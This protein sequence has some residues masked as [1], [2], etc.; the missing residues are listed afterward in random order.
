[1][2]RTVH[3]LAMTS[4]LH[5][6]LLGP[7]KGL[8]VTPLLT[9][10]RA[11]PYAHVPRR[12]ARSVLADRLPNTSTSASIPFDATREGPSSI[13]PWNSART[14]AT[15]NQLPTSNIPDGCGDDQSE[16]CL[17]L[18]ITVPKDTPPTAKLPVLLF[19][20]GGAFFLGASTRPYY[21][22]LTLLTQAV[23]ASTPLIFVALNYRLGA[24]GFFHSPEAADLMPPNNGL[25]DQLRAFE[26]VRRHIGGFGGD[27]G[28]VTAVGQSAGGESLSLH[29]ISGGEEKLYRRC[30][31]FSGSPV[32]MPCKT[33][34]E[35]Q[36]NFLEQARGMGI[37]TEGRGSEDVAR[38]M[39]AADVDEVRKLAFVGAPCSS[40]EVLPYEK[41]TML[42]TRRTRPGK[43]LD[44]LVV[45]AAEYDGG[46]SYNMLLNDESRKG[47]AASFARIARDVLEEPQALMDLYEIKEEEDDEMA[48]RKICQF[49]SDIGFL[50][51][52]LSEAMGTSEAD[53]L[54]Q[55][56]ESSTRSRPDTYLQLFGLGNP[57]DGPLPKKEYATHTWDIVALLGAYEDQ[58]EE[59]TKDVIRSWR[60]KFI[61]FAVGKDPWDQW[62][63]KEGRA[64]VVRNEGATVQKSNDYVGPKSRRG[65]L[66][67]IARREG[68]DEGWDLLWEGVCRRFLMKGE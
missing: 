10:F 20:H 17:H 43:W 21:S 52:A 32:T 51:A 54:D 45:S 11:L 29:N 1:M 7:I 42:L 56:K 13:Q 47:H 53:E 18:T 19:L 46:I 14:D 40:S 44:K 16:D 5:H 59:G 25:H 39:I 62:T 27:A 23:N 6:P 15:G 2:L 4:I 55:L 30:V 41:P 28:N 22:A 31:L 64:L 50:A 36:E 49:E 26:W 34:R 33:P 58:L 35:H 12:F 8:N 61:D 37:Q 65:R 67:E 60:A 66:L 57:F 68:G 63:P 48:L 24:L 38:E 9:Q 3:Q